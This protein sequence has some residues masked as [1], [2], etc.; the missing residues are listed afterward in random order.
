M[1]KKRLANA[2]PKQIPTMNQCLKPKI[3]VRLE[4]CSLRKAAFYS[5]IL[6][7]IF[8]FAKW[9]EGDG[10]FLEISLVGRQEDT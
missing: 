7:L 10:G 1:R 2:A 3:E 9:V 5:D 8:V 6:L 4:N